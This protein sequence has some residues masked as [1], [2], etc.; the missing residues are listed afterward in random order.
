[1]TRKELEMAQSFMQMLFYCKEYGVDID[2][3][4]PLGDLVGIYEQVI[5]E[6]D[7]LVNV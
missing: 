7:G 6:E 1:M 2:G 5:A 3:N 4:V